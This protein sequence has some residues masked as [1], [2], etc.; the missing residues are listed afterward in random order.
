[1]LNL[2]VRKVTARLYNVN[3]YVQAYIQIFFFYLGVY[4]FVMT[5]VACISLGLTLLL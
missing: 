4:P 3:K 2:M 5:K 1:M